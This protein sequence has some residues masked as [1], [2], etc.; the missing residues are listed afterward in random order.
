[1]PRFKLR[2]VLE[3]SAV[4]DLWRHTLS[5]IPTTFG[6]L[7]YLA[8]LRDPN[9]GVYRHHGLSSVF[10]RDESIKALR[11]SHEQTFLE[12]IGLTMEEKHC[13]LR[14]YLIAIEEPPMDF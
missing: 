10:G 6:R 7:V 4:S 3:R 5:H 8:S 13:D 1:M 12:W 11:E 14:Q 2:G 9:S